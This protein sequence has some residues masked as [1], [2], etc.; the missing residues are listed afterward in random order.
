M[1]AAR[2]ASVGAAASFA[3]EKKERTRLGKRVLEIEKDE[4]GFD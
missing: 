4:K 2:E 3:G 1:V